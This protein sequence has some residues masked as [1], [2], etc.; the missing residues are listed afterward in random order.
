MWRFCDLH[1]HSFPNEVCDSP[2]DPEAFVRSSVDVA[3]HVVGIADHDCLEVF[4]DIVAVAG[5]DL[6]V[7]PSVELSTDRGHLLVLAPAA[8]GQDVIRE[9]L[10]R[11]GA[12]P[13]HQIDLLRFFEA[14]EEQSGVGEPFAALTVSIG[15]HV[16]A[17]GQLL[18][19]PNPLSI[20]RQLD[21][22]ARLD[23]VEVAR[24]EVFQEWSRA[25]VKQGPVLPLLRGSDTHDPADRRK[26]GT[27][28]YLP[29]VSVS[30]FQ[31]AFAVPES[32]IRYDGPAT[33]PSYRIDAVEFSDGLHGGQVLQ[34]SQLTDV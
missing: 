20:E 6:I 15:A 23:A 31:H 30:A 12:R 7:V 9:F 24:D 29:Q 1:N 19:S 4:E 25:G 34:E 27:W 26:I 2:W 14:R 32:S 10:T 18:G 11:L 33:T 13:G 16:D 22:A 21:Y 8:G 3:L 5:D 28:L 17:D